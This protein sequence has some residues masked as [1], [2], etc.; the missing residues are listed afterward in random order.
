MGDDGASEGTHEAFPISYRIHSMLPQPESHR[1]GIQAAARGD[2]N[3]SREIDNGQGRKP[4]TTA[5]VSLSD[6]LIPA[7]LGAGYARRTKTAVRIPIATAPPLVEQAQRLLM[8]IW[9]QTGE[10]EAIV[11][12]VSEF[13][14]PAQLSFA[15]FNRLDQVGT[16][17]GMSAGRMQILTQQEQILVARYGEAFRHVTHMDPGNI[18]AERRFRW[19]PGLRRQS[20][21]DKSRKKGRRRS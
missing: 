4:S 19:Q 17:G 15:E 8:K 10:I 6:P 3:V 2:E 18:L 11:L 5:L 20:G 21:S 9:P 13:E 14:E 12:E 1:G 7:H 16:L